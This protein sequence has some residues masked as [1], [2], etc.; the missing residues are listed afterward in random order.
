MTSPAD[1]ERLIEETV[2][3]HRERDREGRIL[4]SASF[5]DLDPEDRIEAFE[6]TLRARTI[7]AALDPEGLSSTARALLARIRGGA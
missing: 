4:P 3:A 2:S 6:E 1:R 5:H 7:E